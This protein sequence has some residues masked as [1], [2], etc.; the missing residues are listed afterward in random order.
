MSKLLINEP[1]LQV[2]PT[3]AAWIG[4]NESIVIQQIHYWLNNPKVGKTADDKKWIRN[5]YREWQEDNFPFWDENTIKR[6]FKNLEDDGLILTRDDL[7]QHDYDQTKWFSIDYDILTSLD[8]P[9]GRIKSK[10]KKRK[11]A[12]ASRGVQNVPPPNMYPGGAQNVPNDTRDY[13]ETQE[14]D[15]LDSQWS[16]VYTLWQS[17]INLSES[18][19]TIQEMKS[20]EY[21]KIPYEWWE[22]AIKIACDNK[23]RRWSYVRGIL[24]RSIDQ[25]LAPNDCTVPKKY[26]LSSQKKGYSTHEVAAAKTKLSPEQAALA[27]ELARQDAAQ[28][29]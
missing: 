11:K 19:I 22:Q 8:G 13:S 6:A 16:K 25:G 9:V 17:N 3:L 28:P 10:K 27:A 5:S 29:G 4:L 15:S 1:P 21:L 24:D 20:E 26:N 23:A 7:N 18:P 12:R 14:E 2:L